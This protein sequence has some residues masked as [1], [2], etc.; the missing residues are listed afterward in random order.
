MFT[1]L[2]FLQVFYVLVDHV[3][4]LWHRGATTGASPAFMHGDAGLMHWPDLGCR[5]YRIPQAVIGQSLV[6]SGI[7]LDAWSSR[8]TSAERTG[9]L[10]RRTRVALGWIRLEIR[11]AYAFLDMSTW[12]EE[13]Y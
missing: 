13:P 10:W 7:V 8:R 6:R 1:T 12:A 4:P 11:T 2:K 9:N 5:V 3:G